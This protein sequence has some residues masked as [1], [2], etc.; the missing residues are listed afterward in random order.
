MARIGL[1]QVYLDVCTQQ[2]RT[3]QLAGK[4]SLNGKAR[5]LLSVSTHASNRDQT[6][7]DARHRPGGRRLL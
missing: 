3:R 6:E 4:H 1:R 7:Q 5:Q 2:L